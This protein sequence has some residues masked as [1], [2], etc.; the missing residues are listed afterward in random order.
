MCIWI[1][2]ESLR[3]S[4]WGVIQQFKSPVQSVAVSRIYS[5]GVWVE[6]NLCFMPRCAHE[7]VSCVYGEVPGHSGDRVAWHVRSVGSLWEARMV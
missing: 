1:A 7:N 2:M 5:S 6:W 3:V 4:N